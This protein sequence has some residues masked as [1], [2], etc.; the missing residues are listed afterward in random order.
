[1]RAC[2]EAAEVL[3]GARCAVCKEL[4]HQPTAAHATNAHVEPDAGQAR[5]DALGDVHHLRVG[6]GLGSG[7]GFGFGFAFGFGFGF[8]FG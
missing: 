1:M 4:E 7:F 5:A 6:L 8:G 3:R 2:A